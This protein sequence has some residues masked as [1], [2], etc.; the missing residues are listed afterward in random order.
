MNQET[1]IRYLRQVLI[2]KVV[3]TI[4][5]WGL[6]AFIAPMTLLSF[7]NLPVPV[8]S[9]YLRLFGG[10]AIAWG[11]AYWYVYQDPVKNVAIIKAGLVDNALPT[12]AVFWYGIMGFHESVFIWIS[13]LL[14]GLFFFA[15]LILMPRE[16]RAT[17]I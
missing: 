15:F 6:P 13:G 10:A 4:F 8:E 5:V 14:T 3:I 11:V 2:I 1:R 17:S 16:V 7:L 12:I 9:I